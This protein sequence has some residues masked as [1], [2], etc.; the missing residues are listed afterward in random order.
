MSPRRSYSNTAVVLSPEDYDS[1]LDCRDLLSEA[2]E[3]LRKASTCSSIPDYVM[4]LIRSVLA[5]RK[6]NNE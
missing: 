1:L 2:M 4:E 6:Q 3:A 5:K